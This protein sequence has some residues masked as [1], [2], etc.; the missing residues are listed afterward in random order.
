[1][2]NQNPVNLIDSPTKSKISTK[3][4]QSFIEIESDMNKKSLTAL[5]RE[6]NLKNLIF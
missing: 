4:S 5:V 2:K 6:K 3:I 1:M